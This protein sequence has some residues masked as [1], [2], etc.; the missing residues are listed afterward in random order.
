M[1][2]A[3]EATRLTLGTK[4]GYA[5]GNIGLQMLVAAMNFLLMI[6]RACSCPFCQCE[7]ARSVPIKA[8]DDAQAGCLG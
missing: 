4:L 7:R 8:R 3:P 6:F 5:T 2:G 1:R